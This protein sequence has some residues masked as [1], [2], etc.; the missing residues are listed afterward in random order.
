[1][2]NNNDLE[3]V[4]SE[5]IDKVEDAVDSQVTESQT[6]L[7]VETK[8]E[9]TEIKEVKDIGIYKNV[10]TNILDKDKLISIPKIPYEQYYLY[11]N[12]VNEISK[13]Y[14]ENNVNASLSS[15]FNVSG[16]N[17]T[18]SKATANGFSID[19]P[20]VLSREDVIVGPRKVTR[21]GKTKESRIKSIVSNVISGGQ[22]VQFPLNNSGF[23]ITMTHPG[24]NELFECRKTLRNLA[25]DSEINVGGLLY[26]STKTR[27]INHIID[28]A[29]EYI[30]DTTLDFDKGNLGKRDFKQ[31]KKYIDPMDYPFIIACMG[32][33]LTPQGNTTSITC[34]NTTVIE[35]TKD[36]KGKIT[37]KPKCDY[38]A[39][40]TLSVKDTIRLKDERYTETMFDIISRV[41]SKTVSL[42][43]LKTYQI[44]R[45][46]NMS[47]DLDKI[48]FSGNGESITF[49]LY[50]PNYENYEKVS[51]AYVTN[52]ENILYG[53]GDAD[54]EDRDKTLSDL[55]EL[56]KL[57]GFIHYLKSVDIGSDTIDLV[58]YVDEEEF[59][60]NISEVT[61]ILSEFN[62]DNLTMNI[63]LEKLFEFI[64]YSNIAS[65]A[66]NNFQC[67]KCKEKQ[68]K[69]DELIWLDPLNYFLEILDYRFTNIL[70]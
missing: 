39:T 29:L 19:S 22:T 31:I 33:S 14:M 25:I 32:M 36:S 67:P 61:E 6:E 23:Q 9:T 69:D 51:L 27:L 17:G 46:K 70:E 21:T 59:N 66:V 53:L 26:N 41:K 50:N 18:V 54:N 49:N 52:L 42:D 45:M 38:I 34:V 60:K 20:S 65:L 56:N 37:K 44:E 8:T 2:E 55:L 68:N 5:P 57:S 15:Y 24:T 48:T 58:N 64:S 43:D 40:A 4:G 63:Y 1:M 7:P 16:M 11:L 30:Q 28:F 10:D 47:K 3:I 12:N 13:E 35:E 62:S